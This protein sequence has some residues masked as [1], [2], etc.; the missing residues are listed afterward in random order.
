MPELRSHRA[1]STLDL[2]RI[3]I[4][5]DHPSGHPD[6]PS[7]LH[8][9]TVAFSLERVVAFPRNHWSP[10]DWNRWS[11]STGIRT[12]RALYPGI[13]EVDVVNHR[14][15]EASSPVE[16]ALG[17]LDK[18]GM[19]VRGASWRA[20]EKEDLSEHGISAA[21]ASRPVRVPHRCLT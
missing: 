7:D 19:K 13:S 21:R 4:H 20:S 14:R 5:G 16:A 2:T 11:P 1:S 18:G 15:E 8:V 3:P 17:G 6:H 12:G 9:E 10:S